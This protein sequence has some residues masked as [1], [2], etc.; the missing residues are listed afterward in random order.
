MDLEKSYEKALKA[1]RLIKEAAK[2]VKEARNE[3]EVEAAR[4]QLR[5]IQGLVEESEQLLYSLGERE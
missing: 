1:E 2:R 5:D 3:E 4:K